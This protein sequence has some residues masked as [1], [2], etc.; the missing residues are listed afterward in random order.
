MW[1]FCFLFSFL[2]F[3][4]L[5]IESWVM[6]CCAVLT[7]RRFLRFCEDT[8]FVRKILW[9]VSQLIKLI[10]KEGALDFV[11]ASGDKNEIEPSLIWFV[12]WCFCFVFFVF[13]FLWLF[14]N[15][16]TLLFIILN[17]VSFNLSSVPFLVMYCFVDTLIVI[18][19]CCSNAPLAFR[20]P[21]W[22]TTPGRNT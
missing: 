6:Y 5:L 22:W 15:V 14:V 13:V 9:C 21:R 16:V 8:F 11:M 19:S 4:F 7:G 2:F 20:K 12:V 17:Y 3:S 18:I 1:L 10:Q